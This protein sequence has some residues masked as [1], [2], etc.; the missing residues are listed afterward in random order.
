[1][2]ILSGCLFFLSLNT[3]WVFV[4]VIVYSRWDRCNVIIGAAHLTYDGTL[5]SAKLLKRVNDLTLSNFEVPHRAHPHLRSAQVM[6]ATWVFPAGMWGLRRHSC[7]SMRGGLGW[8]SSNW[9]LLTSD[10]PTGPLSAISKRLASVC[11]TS[12]C[13][14]IGPYHQ[15]HL[16]HWNWFSRFE[17][18]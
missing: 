10:T 2:H 14:C 9:S 7:C 11:I 1:M 18:L 3:C 6:R 15:H 4:T 8:D 17:S 16:K 13:V 5:H 12:G